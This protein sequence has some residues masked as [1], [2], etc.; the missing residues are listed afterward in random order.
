[1]GPGSRLGRDVV[2]GHGVD[3]WYDVDTGDSEA[4]AALVRREHVDAAVCVLD[5]SFAT[6]LEAIGCPVVFVDS[7]PF[8]WTRDDTASLPLRAS[9][10]CAQLCLSLP[11][12][13]WPVMAQVDNLRWVEAVVLRLRPARGPRS[14]RPVSAPPW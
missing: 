6:A 7:L 11:A 1:M 10:S 5:R 9:A 2:R 13:A 8:L 3:D 14:V 4:L 12:P